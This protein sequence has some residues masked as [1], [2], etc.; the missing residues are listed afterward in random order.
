MFFLSK[1]AIYPLVQKKKMVYHR[2]NQEAE[3]SVLEKDVLEKDR[4]SI[5][6]NIPATEYPS[7]FLLVILFPF[8]WM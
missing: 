3:E 4:Q 6:I 2:V 5:T 7:I 8:I 1:Y